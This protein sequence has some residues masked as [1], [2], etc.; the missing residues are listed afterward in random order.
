MEWVPINWKIIANPVNW[1]I[2]LLMLVI[3]SFVLHLL[4]PDTFNTNQ[5]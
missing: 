3:A 4:L 5:Q 2:V 1:A